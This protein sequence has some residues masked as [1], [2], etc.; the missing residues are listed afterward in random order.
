MPTWD[1]TL[2]TG[3]SE[4]DTQHRALFACATRLVEAAQ[5]GRAAAEL[6]DSIQFL[7]VYV[8]QHFE[9]EEAL[10]RQHAYPEVEAHAEIHRRISRRLGEVVAAYQ[11]H[12]GTGGLVGDVEA[13]MRGWV[14]LH[15]GEKDR[16]FV[17]FLRARGA[18]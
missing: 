8:H 11:A 5:G 17:E 13:M 15:I 4:I 18:A 3:N 16:A 9:A 2:D 14:S 6:A 12:G 7:V 10:M 1:P